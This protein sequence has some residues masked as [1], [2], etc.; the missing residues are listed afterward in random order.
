MD[1]MSWL[2][3]EGIGSAEGFMAAGA[4]GQGTFLGATPGNHFVELSKAMTAGADI[5]NPGTSPGVGFALRRE[6]LDPVLTSVTYKADDCRFWKALAKPK[7][8]QTVEEYNVLEAYGTHDSIFVREGELPTED[9][10]T[11]SRNYVKMKFMG[12]TCR[13]TH[14]MDVID[15]AHGPAVA[16]EVVNGTL[17]LLKSLEQH[18]FTGDENLMAEAF[19]GV[20]T[21]MAKAFG[22]TLQDDGQYAGYEDDNVIDLRNGNINE[23]YIAD[24]SEILIRRPNYGQPNCLWSPTGVKRDLSKVMYPKER[25]DLPAPQNG[26]AGIQIGGLVTPFG[27]LKLEH[28][29]FLEASGVPGAAQGAAALRPASPTVGTPT[30][31]VYGGSSTNQWAAADAGAYYYKIVACSRNGK[32]AAVT[33]AQVTVSAGDEVQIPVTDNGPGTTYYEVYRS[34]LNGAASTCRLIMKVA[35]T[36]TTQTLRDLNRFLPNT[37]K[38]YMLT[39][40]PEVLDWMQLLPFTKIDLAVIDPSIRWMQLMYGAL[41]LRAPRRNGMF[42]NVGNLQTGA[43]S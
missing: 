16:R 13:V 8:R 35:K 24:L 14:V 12:T 15:T 21:L 7:A 1:Y 2:G 25:Y 27:Q 39:Q 23:D 6:S 19:D 28:N 30:S 38:S 40:T 41:R 17:R 4:G 10:S 34:D 42:I 32:S 33:T 22:S 37:S 20:E 18:L 26:M 43:Y 31:P 36:A 9:D 29:I 3:A 11:Y 5:N